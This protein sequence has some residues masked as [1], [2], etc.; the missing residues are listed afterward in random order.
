MDTTA[1]IQSPL[2]LLFNSGC[3]QMQGS[4]VESKGDN[5][6]SS[7]KARIRTQA[8]QNCVHIMQ[9]ILHIDGLVQDC[10]NS[11]AIAMELLQ[12]CSKPLIY[13]FIWIYNAEIEWSYDHLIS[14]MGGFFY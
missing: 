13:I 3:A 8:Q 4:D 1:N 11:S 6:A 14:T 7:G 2:A 5:L 12:S 10:S 9:D